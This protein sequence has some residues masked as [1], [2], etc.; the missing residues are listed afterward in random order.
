MHKT[1]VTNRTTKMFQIKSTTKITKFMIFVVDQHIPTKAKI[2]K[3]II[4]VHIQNEQ[5]NIC[6]AYRFL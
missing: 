3:F 4:F 2:M 6:Q 1:N 5:E